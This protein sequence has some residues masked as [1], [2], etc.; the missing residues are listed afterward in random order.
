VSARFSV[1]I[2]LG[3][4]HCALAQA[5]L[6][7]DPPGSPQAQ[8]ITQLVARDRVDS[9]V[10]LPSFL[11]FP[12]SSEGAL[13]LPWDP[14]SD[15][16]VGIYARR[17]AAESPGRVVASSKSWLSHPTID[18]HAPLLPLGAPEDITT[19]SPIEAAFRLLEH[20]SSAWSAERWAGAQLGE[21]EVTLT[22]PASFDAAARDFTVQA[23]SA[24]GFNHLTLL[25][26]PQAAFYAWLEQRGD[27]W[28]SDLK[29]GDLVLVVD[30]G[31]GT[32]DFAAILLE[33][34]DG[35][36]EPRRVAVGQHLLLGGD[37]MDLALAHVVRQKLEN[38]GARIDSWQL[39]SLTH[40]AREAKEALL[41]ARAPENVSVVLPSRGSQLLGG[42]LRSALTREEVEST[43]ADGF[44]P[45]VSWQA[46]PR[47]RPRTALRQ[48]GLPY[49][50]DPSITT[51]LA[52]FLRGHRAALGSAGAAEP[53]LLAPTHVLFNGGVFRSELLRTR[54]LDTVN[55]WLTEIGRPPARDL[56]TTDYDLA[57]ARGASYYGLVRRGRGV[58]VRGGTAQAFY[59]GIESPAP[60]VPG[61]EPPTVALCVA[62]FGM[63]E[64]SRIQ[65][66]EVELGVIVGES[67]TFRF[68]GSS[69]RRDD[70]AGT[71]LEDPERTLDELAPIAITLPS[72]GRTPGEVVAVTLESAI[73]EVG[74]LALSARPLDPRVPDEHWK[75]ELSVRGGAQPP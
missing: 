37:N 54:L 43:V 51:H 21:Q 50:E 74:T 49:A 16:A 22:V 11:Y 26:E 14:K 35:R 42:S 69:V 47:Q 45:R 12:H 7:A 24:A 31:G 36:L 44:F 46:E 20:L 59:V 18:R 2:D 15:L 10:L 6:E 55:S 53:Q 58:R 3:T 30:V 72:Q 13:A 9:A 29:V 8:P 5:E 57:V 73:T 34:R 38:A 33:E 17:R 56:P 41:A 61:L 48:R 67:V 66:P 70:A 28:R 39:M 75:V 4:T 27:A 19:I 52:A 63:E 40:T 32:S 68:F 71:M 25:E 60:A 23:A 64:G 62:P 1:G 65:L